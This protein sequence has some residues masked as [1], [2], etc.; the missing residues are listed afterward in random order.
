[1][2]CNRCG[3]NKEVCN[4]KPL[5]RETVVKYVMEHKWTVVIMVTWFLGFLVYFLAAGG[6]PSYAHIDTTILSTITNQTG[7]YEVQSVVTT[8]VYLTQWQLA[9]L[10]I[11][12]FALFSLIPFWVWLA[13]NLYDW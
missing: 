2:R 6:F 12:Y 8:I 5:F 1:M 9:A 7:T 3:G 4:C 13:A 10:Y 11:A